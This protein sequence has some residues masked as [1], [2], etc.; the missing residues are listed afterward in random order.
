MTDCALPNLVLSSFI[1]MT[2]SVTRLA[3]NAQRLLCL[4]LR[5]LKTTPLSALI[6]VRPQGPHL[7]RILL[8]RKRGGQGAGSI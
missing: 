3:L 6:A 8:Q 1:A 2:L 5:T 7:I 4:G